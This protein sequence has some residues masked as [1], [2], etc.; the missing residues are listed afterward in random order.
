MRQ[1]NETGRTKQSRPDPGRRP[2]M[3]S[4]MAFAVPRLDTADP[5]FI[6]VVYMT[7]NQKHHEPIRQLQALGFTEYEARAYV[8]LLE[9]GELSGYA[10]AK[11]S[12]IPRANIYAVLEKL[13]THGAVSRSEGRTGKSWIA[14]P[15]DVLLG[16]LRAR[17]GRALE[18]ATQALADLGHAEVPATVF[19]LRDDELLARAGQ[20]IDA[21]GESLLI[22]IQPTEAAQLAGPLR[23]ARERGIRVTTLCLEACEQPCGG[24]QG[25]LHR[26]QLA[27]AHGPRWL[28]VVADHMQ[29]LVGQLGHRCAD[30]VATDQRLV[31]ELAATYIQQS[32]VLAALDSEL[33]GGSDGL[34][35]RRTMQRLSALFPGKSPLSAPDR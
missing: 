31:V 17:H 4:G 6:V 15:D 22:A 24:C 9:Q 25:E 30:G 20:L 32:L 2:G 33:G 8:T 16:S 18:R 11:E 23:Q 29:T 14:V 1:C 13:M 5:V 10:L 19:N 7:T 34:P 12:G 35:S 21:A 27:P 26:H 3:A 28:I